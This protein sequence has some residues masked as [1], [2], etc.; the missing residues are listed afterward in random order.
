M[1]DNTLELRELPLASPKA[2]AQ[3]DDFLCRAGLQRDELDYYAGLFAGSKLVAGG[4]YA[5]RTVKCLAVD[6]SL[7]SAGLLS[8]V[9]THLYTRLVENGADNVFIFTQ[10]E[11]ADIFKSLGFHTVGS[12][13]AAILLESNPT[14]LAS[15]LRALSASRRPGL[16][17]AI[18]VNCNPFTLGHQYL[19]ETAA[20]QCDHLHL[21]V[22][23]EDRSVF[24]FAV[25][26]SLIEKGTAHLPNITIH[27]GCDYIIS[28]ATFPTYF[29]KEYSELVKTHAALDIDIF[30]RQIAPVLGIRR[31]F[32]GE[33]PFDPVTAAYNA[34]MQE[35]LPRHAIDL[36]VIPR[37]TAQDTPI[38]ASLVRR[39]IAAGR[40]EDTRPLLP[41]S[42]FDYLCSE[43]AQPVLNKIRA[44]DDQADGK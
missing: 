6:A 38:S 31:R 24:P 18:V 33:E 32:A 44:S 12:A 39:L 13:P 16:A 28:A 35:I 17:A 43:A 10:P 21:F 14:G 4:G 27:A 42:T 34:A 2:L 20:A 26:R 41:A 37:K 11:K 29:L 9:M 5:G 15:Y 25:R 22:V 1:D 8:R 7:R 23:S 40:L 30:A 36:V 3:L 19:I